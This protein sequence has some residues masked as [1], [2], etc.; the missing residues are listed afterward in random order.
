MV[1]KLLK[2]IH[3]FAL[4]GHSRQSFMS[5]DLGFFVVFDALS[6][7]V[8]VLV[9]ADLTKDETD[10]VFQQAGLAFRVLFGEKE[11]EGVDL[12]FG[13]EVAHVIHNAVLLEQGDLALVFE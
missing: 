12:L 3:V 7:E 11:T 4:T 6:D 9:A 5:D 8:F 2:I 13:A 1:D 10:F